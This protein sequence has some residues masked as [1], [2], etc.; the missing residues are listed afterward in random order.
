MNEMEKDAVKLATMTA[1]QVCAKMYPATWHLRETEKDKQLSL[2]N[3][4]RHL[5]AIRALV[6]S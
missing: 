4:Q 1:E 6:Q 5:D 2:R 3:A